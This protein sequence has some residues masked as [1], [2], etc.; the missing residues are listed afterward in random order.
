MDQNPDQFDH[1]QR[2]QY[3]HQAPPPLLLRHHPHLNQVNQLRS[4]GHFH[5]ELEALVIPVG[6][7][8]ERAYE[9]RPDIELHMTFDGS[10][11]SMLGTY[12]ASCVVYESIYGASSVDVDYDYFGAV[13]KDDA[14]FLQKVAEETVREFFGRD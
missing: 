1:S 6:L 11:P 3:L 9:L 7:A 5:N 2:Y 4:R 10:H 12:L 14:A 13:N 8:F